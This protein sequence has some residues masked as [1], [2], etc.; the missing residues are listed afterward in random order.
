MCSVHICFEK[1]RKT[2]KYYLWRHP[3]PD[4]LPTLLVVLWIRGEWECLQRQHYTWQFRIVSLPRNVAWD[5][6]W[7][8]GQCCMFLLR[9]LWC[10]PVSSACSTFMSTQH[11]STTV[12]VSQMSSKS[13]I[14]IVT[15]GRKRF[16]VLY[17]TSRLWG[18]SNRLHGV[19]TPRYQVCVLLAPSAIFFRR[20]FRGHLLDH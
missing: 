17:R 1:C 20:V 8:K 11:S 14:N 19:A 2:T 13:G 10:S 15:F 4:L 12:T 6:W 9:V 16:S 3:V 7:T 5:L 18:V